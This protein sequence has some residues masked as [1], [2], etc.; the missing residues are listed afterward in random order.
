MKNQA[1]NF[2]K[3]EKIVQGH[4]DDC[5]AEVEKGKWAPARPLGY[6]SFRSRLRLA[7]MVFTGKCDALKWPGQ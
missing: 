7:W 2:V 5:Q 4:Y 3:F 6:D 1:P